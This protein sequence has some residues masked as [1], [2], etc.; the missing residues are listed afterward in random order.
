MSDCRP[1]VV[2]VG[3]GFA[4]LWAVRALATAKVR[5]TLVDRGNHH[6]FQP[7]LYQVAAG[8]LPPDVVQKVKLLRDA[9][10]EPHV[11]ETGLSRDTSVD[12]AL[13]AQ[14]GKAREILS[15][16]GAAA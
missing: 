6:L 10:E 7:L 3:G 4:G 2:I 16:Y 11:A 9:G 8:I 14:V 12:R 15:K 1:H 5:I 13:D